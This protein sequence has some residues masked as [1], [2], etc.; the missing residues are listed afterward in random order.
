MENILLSDYR[1]SFAPRSASWPLPSHECPEFTPRLRTAQ[2]TRPHLPL[3][4]PDH[5]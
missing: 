5:E 2:Q 1:A 3:A 4:R